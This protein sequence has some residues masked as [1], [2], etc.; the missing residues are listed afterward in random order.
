MCLQSLTVM[1]QLRISRLSRSIFAALRQL[2]VNFMTRTSFNDASMAKKGRLVRCVVDVSWFYFG[3]DS[4]PCTLKTRP[5]IQKHICLDPSNKTGHR[6][7]SRLTHRL[8]CA[9][10]CMSVEEREIEDDDEDGS[11]SESGESLIGWSDGLVRDLKRKRDE[12]EEMESDEEEGEEN[13][14]DV[15][16]E[17]EVPNVQERVK[18]EGGA[19][20]QKE[21][22]QDED[23]EHDETC[24]CEEGEVRRRMKRER[25]LPTQDDEEE[26]SD[27][28]EEEESCECVEVRG[29]SSTK[30]AIRS[31][32]CNVCLMV[33]KDGQCY[34]TDVHHWPCSKLTVPGGPEA[35][36]WLHQIFE[37][38]LAVFM[39]RNLIHL[40]CR[41]LDIEGVYQAWR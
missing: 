31:I 37:G 22:Q 39:L 23:G 2:Q 11:D 26:E 25:E 8:Q 10:V 24:D 4:S 40:V 19:G 20:A 30:C 6:A 17:G 16:G 18:D 27:S 32:T 29:C 28:E 21:C 9:P 38:M 34:S 35:L 41:A 13:P 36:R 3:E 15:R 5:C 7:R 14:G 1:L 12:E 33:F